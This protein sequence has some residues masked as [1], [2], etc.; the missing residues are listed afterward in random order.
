VTACGSVLTITDKASD[1]TITVP[2]SHG[3]IPATAI[4]QIK[5][6]QTCPQ[7]EPDEIPLRVYDPGFK[8]TAVCHTQISAVDPSGKLYYRGYDVEDLVNHSSF[9]EV[10]F[11][12]IYGHLPTKVSAARARVTPGRTQP[13]SCAHTAA[14]H[15]PC[16]GFSCFYSWR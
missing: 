14:R 10:A 8:N 11:L 9:L 1:K 15:T 12:L 13:S 2:V 7:P 3:A 5:I 16:W 4:A 6:Q